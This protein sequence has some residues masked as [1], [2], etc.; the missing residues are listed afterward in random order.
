M[1]FWSDLFLYS[2]QVPFSYMLTVS[3][4]EQVTIARNISGVILKLSGISPAVYQ[5]IHSTFINQIERVSLEFA[6]EIVTMKHESYLSVLYK[7]SVL[8]VER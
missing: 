5:C 1:W 3:G 4:N 2:L 7:D 8:I 6:G